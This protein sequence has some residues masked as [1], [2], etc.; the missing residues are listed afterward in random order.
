M[1]EKKSAGKMAYTQPD[2]LGDCDNFQGAQ[3]AFLERGCFWFM[4]NFCS[5]QPVKNDS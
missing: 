2:K 4:V 5:A 3:K 1:R